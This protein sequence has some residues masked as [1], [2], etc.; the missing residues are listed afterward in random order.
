MRLNLQQRAERTEKTLAKYRTKPFDWKR[1]ATCIHLARTQARNMGHH[2]PSLPRF[3]SPIGARTALR[4]SG[5][6]TL[7]A[8]LDSLFPRIVPAQM[9][10]GDLALIGSE[11]G[12]G[13]ITIFD[14]LSMLLGWFDEDPSALR[15]VANGMGLVT[16]AWRL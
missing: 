7:E 13:T 12:L 15:P 1:G 3:T 5:H 16:G 11:D 8:L 4:S 6:D 14:G 2:P 9:L 10:V